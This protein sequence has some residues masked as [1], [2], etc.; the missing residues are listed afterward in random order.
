MSEDLAKT[1]VS[2]AETAAIVEEKL[3]RARVRA[4]WLRKPLSNVA[5]KFLTVEHRRFAGADLGDPR[6]VQLIEMR[7]RCNPRCLSRLFLK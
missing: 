5:A 4:I 3:L 1:V 7:L 2:L 6:I